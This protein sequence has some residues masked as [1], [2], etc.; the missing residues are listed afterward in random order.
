MS[1]VGCIYTVLFRYYD[2]N[3]REIK[4]KK[5]PFLV[6]KEEDGDYPKDLTVLPISTIT[7]KKRRNDTYDI[8]IENK[9]YPELNLNMDVSYIR[10]HKA[11]TINEKDLLKQICDNCNAFYPDLYDEIREKLSTFF[12]FDIL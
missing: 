10:C 4:F 9:R 12:N 8:P 2:V 5:R 7:N 1:K 6:I 3:D 11:Q